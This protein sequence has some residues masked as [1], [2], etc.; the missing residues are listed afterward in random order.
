MEDLANIEVQIC[1]ELL[2]LV[3][4]GDPTVILSSHYLGSLN[5]L[6]K[7]EL[8]F[9]NKEKLQLTEKGREAKTMGIRVYFL[10]QKLEN[11]FQGL[12]LEEQELKAHGPNLSL[13]I[14]LSL[15]FVALLAVFALMS[16]GTY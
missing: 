12:P 8:I 10:K 7:Y 3:E 2:R 9:I 5:Q 4:D 1:D 13:V 16:T 11:N 6:I 15:F 14:I